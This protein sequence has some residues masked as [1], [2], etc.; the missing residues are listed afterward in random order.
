[1]KVPVSENP[2]PDS[3]ESA[4]LFQEENQTL[5]PVFSTHPELWLQVA[6]C[7]LVSCLAAI[8]RKSTATAS[9]TPFP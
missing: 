9:E 4:L 6:V 5:N 3:L 8:E 1:M 7:S 2:S